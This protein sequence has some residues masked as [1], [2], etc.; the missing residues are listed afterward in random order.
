MQDYQL[1]GGLRLLTAVEKT[2]SFGDFLKTRMVRA[3]ESE[4]PTE[5][6]Y[7]LAQLD[8]YHSYMWRYYKKLAKDRAERMNPGV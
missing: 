5:L 7:L 6:H 2:E 8:D 4:D 3:L 1:G